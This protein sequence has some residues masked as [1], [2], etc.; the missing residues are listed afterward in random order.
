[1]QFCSSR[2][3]KKHTSFDNKN[4]GRKISLNQNYKYVYISMSSD[5][6]SIPLPKNN[7]FNPLFIYINILYIFISS[8]YLSP[9]S[10]FFIQTHYSKSSWSPLTS[11]RLLRKCPSDRTILIKSCADFSDLKK[12]PEFPGDLNDLRKWSPLDLRFRVYSS[13][14]A[15][16]LASTL[17]SD[18]RILC[19]SLDPRALRA[20]KKCP[21]RKVLT[22]WS[23]SAPTASGL[24]FKDLKKWAEKWQEIGNWPFKRG[25]FIRQL[26]FI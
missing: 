19:K 23:E 21:D 3:K 14:S 5:W 8:I 22:E 18:L 26:S 17:G 2:L 6:V 4:K 11:L 13:S 1:M 9:K 10:Q 15:S 24:L 20:R 25:S 16:D 7:I 12:W